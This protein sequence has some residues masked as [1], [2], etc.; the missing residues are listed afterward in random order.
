VLFAIFASAF[1]TSSVMAWVPLPPPLPV[2]AGAG[3]CCEPPR[4]RRPPPVLLPRAG[5]GLALR[6]LEVGSWCTMM[7]RPAQI[8]HGSL[9][10]SSSPRPS[11]FRVIC[12]SPSE[13]T[14]AT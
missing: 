14:S 11:F 9:N 10:D 3:C 8:S 7:P 2:L 12:T 1:R 4:P 6:F 5:S 13:V